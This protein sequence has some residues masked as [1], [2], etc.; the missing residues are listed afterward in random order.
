MVYNII[1]FGNLTADFLLC[2][3]YTHCIYIMNTIINVKVDQAVKKKAKKV[4]QDLGLNLSGVV[5]AYLRQFIRSGSLFV[6]SRFEEPSQML[7]SAIKEAEQDKKNKTV[8]SFASPKKALD[9]LDQI[10]SRRNA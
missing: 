9:Y 5:N 1:K 7:I 4:A 10:T 3:I 2:T 6:S 8:K